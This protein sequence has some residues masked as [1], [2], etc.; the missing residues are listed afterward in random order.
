[1]TRGSCLAHPGWDGLSPAAGGRAGGA[2]VYQAVTFECLAAASRDS[3]SAVSQRPVSHIRGRTDREPRVR[4]T[5]SLSPARTFPPA[6]STPAMRL[7]GSWPWRSR[8]QG[9]A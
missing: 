5:A 6:G 1:M 2:G 7:T 3:V 8:P 4:D 9:V